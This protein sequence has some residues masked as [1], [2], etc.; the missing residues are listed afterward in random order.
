[1]V[2]HTQSTPPFSLRH[3]QHSVIALKIPRVG[4]DSKGR[5]RRLWITKNTDAI[6][7]DC[8]VE[9]NQYFRLLYHII[10][11]VHDSDNSIVPDVAKK[12]YARIIRAHLSE[13]ELRVLFYNLMTSHADKMLPL[14]IRYDLLQNMSYTPSDEYEVEHLNQLRGGWEAEEARIAHAILH[15]TSIDM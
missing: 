2:E 9:L 14:A 10:R 6:F 15:Q 13:A 1:M 7:R 12:D 8:K 3:P 11:F 5:A 4:E